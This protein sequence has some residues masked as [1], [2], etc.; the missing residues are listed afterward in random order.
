MSLSSTD[1]NRYH[2]RLSV[3]LLAI[4]YS[5]ALYA[6]AEDRD[7]GQWTLRKE[8]DGI[9]IYARPVS[10]SKYEEFKGV[11]ELDATQASALALLED[12][13]SCTEWLHRCESSVILKRVDEQQRY[14]YQ[15]SNLP[16]PAATRDSII[17]ATVMQQDADTIRVVLESEPE[18]IEETKYVRIRVAKGHYLIRKLGEN[19]IRFTWIQHVDP[20]GTLPAFMVN[21]LLTDLPFKS[22]T[23]FRRLVA[24]EKYSEAK[25][26]YDENGARVGLIY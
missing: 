16:F 14:V 5:G 22:L 12:A 21:S 6:Q 8:K 24:T 19:K 7:S 26:I 13:G 20:A 18:Y 1:L 17:H 4:L 23:N 15:I 11:V 2:A 3:L 25:F 10:G 9:V